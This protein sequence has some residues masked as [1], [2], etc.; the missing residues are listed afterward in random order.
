MAS[1]E[2]TFLKEIYLRGLDGVQPA[3]LLKK[4][5]H[6]HEGKL[7]C[8]NTRI[9][10]SRGGRNILAGSGKAALNM[11]KALLPYLPGNTEKAPLIVP[12]GTPGGEYPLLPGD[13]PL[14]GAN[15][16]RAGK[17][18]LRLLHSA[19]P[20]DTLYYVLTGGSSSL[21]EYP[22]PGISREEMRNATEHFLAKGLSIRE[23]NF[24]RARL[25]RVKGGRLAAECK[26][27]IHV[28]VLS[29]VMGNDMCSI[30]SGP[31][32]AYPEGR[33]DCGELLREYGLD[34]AL[35]PHVLKA[36]RENRPP[37]PPRE[38]PHYLCGSNIDLL[39][40]LSRALKA[41]DI[42][43]LVFPESLF[44]EAVKAGRMIAD[45]IRHYSGPLPIAMIFG[46]ETTVTLGSGPGK[47]GRSQ[48]T[49][50]AALEALGDRKG[51]ALLC[52]G[53]DG[54]DGNSD[55]AGAAVDGSVW[56]KAAEK[57]LSPGACLTAHDSYTF[58]RH[59]GSLIRCGHTGT[60]VNDIAVALLTG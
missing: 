40:A 26:A 12:S 52:A 59:C 50:L 11:A 29:D 22:L 2:T 13:H 10:A 16:L 4:C 56:K 7:Y 20:S 54:I 42:R 45:M 5:L 25:S 27:D 41:R 33:F 58:H 48:E 6:R 35:P 49:A 17:A 37:Q 14:P 28:F 34:T 9:P 19:G 36:L 3:V 23:I 46:G 51:W 8:H 53:S 43:T 31:F 60:N 39:G 44:G 47:G 57:G 38:V 24:L 21:L 1:A 32:Y 18:V 55:A 30:G 15:S